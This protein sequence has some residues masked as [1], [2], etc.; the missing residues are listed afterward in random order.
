MQDL[1]R[2]REQMMDIIEAQISVAL[3]GVS[4][5]GADDNSDDHATESRSEGSC[6]ATRP[7]TRLG[8]SRQRAPGSRRVRPGTGDSARTG[9]TAMT[10]ESTAMSIAGMGRRATA[11][12]LSRPLRAAP[13]APQPVGQHIDAGL[14]TDGNVRNDDAIAARIAQIATKVRPSMMRIASVG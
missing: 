1:E 10:V 7:L 4:T 9:M 2:E 13:R 11:V 5:D 8:D 14:S 6:G 12:T 3:D